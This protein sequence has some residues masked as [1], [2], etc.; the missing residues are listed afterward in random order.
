M[1]MGRI[2][3]FGTAYIVACKVMAIMTVSNKHLA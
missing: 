2:D 3:G 1:E